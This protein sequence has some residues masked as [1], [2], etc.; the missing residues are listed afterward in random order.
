MSPKR[1]R[2]QSS[3]KKPKV[4]QQRSI[5]G[6]QGINIIERIS[7]SLGYAW[8]QTGNLETGIDGYIEIRVP[9]TGETTNSIVQVQ[10]KATDQEFQAE[11][12]TSFEYSCD[13]RDLDYWM[14]GNAPVVLIRSR[15][16]TDEAYWISIKD[17]F[18]D[19]NDRRTRKV[20]FNKQ[21]N[22]FEPSDS[23]ASA[24]KQLA[25]PK[26]SGFYFAPVPKREKLYTNL[27]KVGFPDS[28]Y[29]ARTDYRHYSQIWAEMA[30]IDV[31]VGSD[32]LM[33]RK[34]IMS[35]HDL[36]EYPWNK[37]CE[38]GS[39]ET[40]NTSHWANSH[41]PDRLRDFV[42][43][44]NGCLKE[45]AWQLGLKYS[46]RCECY[47]FR[48]TTNLS[49]RRIRYQSFKEETSRQVFRGYFRSGD[50][51]REKGYYRHSAFIPQFFRHEGEWYL[52][53]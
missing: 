38:A 12:A 34:T 43:L 14:R 9:S 5:L 17:Y 30:K 39:F 16:R 32:F 29:I 33:S 18:A 44:L 28:L 3:T 37:V 1:R 24:L 22:R 26:D 23:C 25:I 47:Y 35:F 53:H 13:E 21:D 46:E 6:Q 19:P 2:I 48:A 10:S 27:I 50:L 42:Q 51:K 8:F 36:D 41:D 40:F 45:K 52:G 49:P 31:S 7:L 11:T 4:L 20:L 15:P